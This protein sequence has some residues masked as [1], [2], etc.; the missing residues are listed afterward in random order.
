M[1]DV[2][3]LYRSPGKYTCPCVFECVQGSGSHFAQGTRSRFLR[4]I[5][6]ALKVS[7]THDEHASDPRGY[8]MARQCETNYVE[9]AG[10]VARWSTWK[11]C[12]ENKRWSRTRQAHYCVGGSAAAGDFVLLDLEEGAQCSLQ[13]AMKH[14]LCAQI[15]GLL[16]ELMSFRKVR[17]TCSANLAAFKNV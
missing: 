5:F 8:N 11:I 13:R 17:D 10:T 2:W 6:F 3:F 12:N 15:C 1:L 14:L 4:R 9:L 16:K 7:R